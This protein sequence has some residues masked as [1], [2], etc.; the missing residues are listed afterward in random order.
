LRC[1]WAD[2]TILLMVSVIIPAY[3]EEKSII[4]CLSSLA[5]QSYSSLELIV[6]DDGSTD[7][8]FQ[9][10]S[11]FKFTK[12]KFQIIKQKHL[13]PAAARNIGARHSKGDILVFIDADMTFAKDFIKDLVEPIDVGKSIGTFSKEEYL[14]NK[15]NIWSLCWNIN[16]YFINGWKLDK[17]VYQRI[18]P[19][20]YPDSQPVFRAIKKTEF[21]KVEGF[22]NIG[23]TDDWTLSRKLKISA[24]VVDGGI[25]Y[26]RNPDTL[27]EIYRQA[28]WIGRNEFLS[29][30][31]IRKLY[32]L[33]RYSFISSV[34]IGSAISINLQIPQFL[35][36][37]IIYDASVTLSILSS[38]VEKSA[39][40]T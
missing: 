36:F 22:D 1:E 4:G 28:N 6:V 39:N 19:S 38:F 29:G 37:K 2:C 15:N 10:L 13:G 25:Y 21:D 34:I 7:K 27:N 8:T 12:I 35:L 11:E 33:I 24:T 5:Q 30:T 26:H 20:Y 16:R 32:N 31:I 17:E 23:Y 3:N 9:I 14:L 18:L 40:K